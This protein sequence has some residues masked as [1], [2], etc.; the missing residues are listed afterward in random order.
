MAAL[1]LKALWIGDKHMGFASGSALDSDLQ[2][3]IVQSLEVRLPIGSGEKVMV[4]VE[5]TNG[6]IYEG[7]MITKMPRDVGRRGSP[8]YHV[9]EFSSQ[10]PLAQAS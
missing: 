5:L 8:T 7:Q 10:T 6:S 9:Y 1:P 4:R 3:L 2:S